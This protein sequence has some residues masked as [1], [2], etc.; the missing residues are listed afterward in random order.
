MQND[1][2][3]VAIYRWLSNRSTAAAMATRVG[4]QCGTY[5]TL[6][7]ISCRRVRRACRCAVSH[8]PARIHQVVPLRRSQ[9][10][11][12]KWGEKGCWCSAP[13]DAARAMICARSDHTTLT[14]AYAL[15]R[16]PA[17][18]HAHAPT[19]ERWAITP[20]AANTRAYTYTT[21][22]TCRPCANDIARL[23]VRPPAASYHRDAR[24]RGTRLCCPDLLMSRG[25]GGG[26]VRTTMYRRPRDV[27]VV[28]VVSVYYARIVIMHI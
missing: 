1:V 22:A 23:P 5:I 18:A 2:D 27:I 6:N 25:G 24:F 3:A 9:I 15:A 19:P 8:G 28:Y 13:S 12:V 26:G 4:P 21:D 16:S 10:R 20:R 11:W 7:N 17:Y 14:L